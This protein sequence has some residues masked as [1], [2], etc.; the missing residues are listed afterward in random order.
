MVGRSAG[1]VNADVKKAL[2]SMHWQP[3]YRYQFSGSAKN[4]QE[5][6]GYAVSALAMAM[7][8]IY[9]ILASQFDS[10]LQPLAMMSALPL[11]L[12]GV[13]PSRCLLRVLP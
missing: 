3:G 11:T 8:F 2:D 5:S 6:F 9:M 10:F 1:Q 7:I 4:M 12:I 13:L